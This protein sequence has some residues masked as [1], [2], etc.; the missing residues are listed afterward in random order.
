MQP[1]FDP[2]RIIIVEEKIDL[3]RYDENIDQ[4]R[5]DEKIR[6][7]KLIILTW[8]IKMLPPIPLITQ[9]QPYLAVTK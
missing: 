5:Y 1:N 4:N 7:N 8:P 2:M 9:D 6:V 3:N